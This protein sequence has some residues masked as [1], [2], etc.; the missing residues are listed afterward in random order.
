MAFMWN[1]RRLNLLQ[2]V[3]WV[4][5][6]R[7]KILNIFINNKFVKIDKYSSE[8]FRNTVHQH[9]HSHKWKIVVKCFCPP[10]T[11]LQA[12]KT[13]THTTQTTNTMAVRIQLSCTE[14]IASAPREQVLAVNSR[15]MDHR[16]D[17]LASRPR[18]SSA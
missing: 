18:T 7:V 4:N 14:A 3:E 2:F 9:I 10:A 1:V 6:F 12:H 8:Q 5:E 13:K 11:I 17:S 16:P 15:K